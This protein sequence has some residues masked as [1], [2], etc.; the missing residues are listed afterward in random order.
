VYNGKGYSVTAPDIYSNRFKVGVCYS[1]V[2]V[3][4]IYSNRFKVRASARHYFRQ[5][6]TPTPHPNRNHSNPCW[7]FR[8]TAA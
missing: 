8:P 3:S 4:L 6:S 5:T 7:S 1:V 2:R